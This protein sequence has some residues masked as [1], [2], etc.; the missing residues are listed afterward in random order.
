MAV[1][2]DG[3]DD[4]R[5][6]IEVGGTDRKVYIFFA[7]ALSSWTTKNGGNHLSRGRYEMALGS[8]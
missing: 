3:R 5:K 1:W 7:H 8:V 6:Q 4:A 2:G